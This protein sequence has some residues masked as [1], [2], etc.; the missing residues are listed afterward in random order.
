MRT[1][2]EIVAKCRD[3]ESS[4]GFHLEVLVPYLPFEYAKEFLQDT[5]VEEEWNSKIIPLTEEN[6]KG[7]MGDY[8]EFA[9]GKVID[10]R[11]L[12][13]SRSI[14]KMV[15]WCW[16]LGDD[17]SVAFAE[18]DKNYAMYGAPILNFICKKHGFPIPDEGEQLERMINGEPCH[19]DCYGCNE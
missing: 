13:A 9:W 2:E 5:V 14:E 19:E 12:S 8:M 7:D 16:L 17:E 6:L 11:G 4:F 3:T 10:H 15:E 18:E 1:F